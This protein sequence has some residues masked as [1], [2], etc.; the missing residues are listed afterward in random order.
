MVG[1]LSIVRFRSAIKDPMD[2]IFM[3]WAISVGIASGVFYLK[4]SIVASLIIA[5]LVILSKWLPSLDKS[6][7]VIIKCSADGEMD[8]NH[9]LSNETKKRQLKSRVFKKNQL[10]LIYEARGFDEKNF[11]G[12]LDNVEHVESFSIIYYQSGA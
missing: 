12:A 5:F 6:F 7:L 1:A 3:F 10:E 4:I 8:V 9:V 2:I 11:S